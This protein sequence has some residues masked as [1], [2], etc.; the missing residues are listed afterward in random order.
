MSP[1]GRAVEFG[2]RE[3]LE[4]G[5]EHGVPNPRFPRIEAYKPGGLPGTSYFDIP[6]R[7]LGL[8]PE[9]A[10]PATVSFEQLS[11]PNPSSVDKAIVGDYFVLRF[12]ECVILSAKERKACAVLRTAYDGDTPLSV[13]DFDE[14]DTD[15]ALGSVVAIPKFE[16]CRF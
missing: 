4:A 6:G 11:V 8:P 15:E 12:A 16:A 5:H 9:A 7:T 10:P 14:V 13:E 2:M 1:W 3:G